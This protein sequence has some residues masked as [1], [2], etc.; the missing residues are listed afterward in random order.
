MSIPRGR[1]CRKRQY[2]GRVDFRMDRRAL[3]IT[4][5]AEDARENPSLRHWRSRPPAERVAAVEFLRRQ[6]IGSDARLR[7][8]L[9][10]VSR[11]LR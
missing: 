11:P 4:M 2:N 1:W 9:R 8:V 7:R 3:K 10:V 6:F 5:F